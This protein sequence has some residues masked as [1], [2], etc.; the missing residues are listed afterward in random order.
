MLLLAAGRGRQRT[1]PHLGCATPRMSAPSM[2]S[3]A[4]GPKEWRSVRPGDGRGGR[5]GDGICTSKQAQEMMKLGNPNP[6]PNRWSSVS[7]PVVTGLDFSETGLET[8]G[9]RSR[10]DTCLHARMVAARKSLVSVFPRPMTP[11]LETDDPSVSRPMTNGLETVSVF[12]E[13]PGLI[14]SPRPPN[15]RVN[16]AIFR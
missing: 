9:H 3:S 1:A 7:R 15:A 5:R 8:G 10:L 6:N 11:G 14:T 2:V 4:T 13:W 12:G 16:T